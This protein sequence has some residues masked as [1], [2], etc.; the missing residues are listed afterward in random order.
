MRE[1]QDIFAFVVSLIG[2]IRGPNGHFFKFIKFKDG[3]KHI[4]IH[5]HIPI[6]TPQANIESLNNSTNSVDSQKK[7]G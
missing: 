7:V 3:N 1:Q 2:L 5:I 6:C 4:C